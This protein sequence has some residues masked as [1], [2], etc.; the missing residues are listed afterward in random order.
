MN[1]K[2]F[3]FRMCI[4]GKKLLGF[5]F[6]KRYASKMFREVAIRIVGHGLSHSILCNESLESVLQISLNLQHH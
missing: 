5:K 4:I 2:V 1:D 6:F 3:K